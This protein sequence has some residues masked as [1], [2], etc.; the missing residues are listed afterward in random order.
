MITVET[1]GAVRQTPPIVGRGVLAADYNNRQ[2]HENTIAPVE[3]GTPVEILDK[4]DELWWRVRVIVA[5]RQADGGSGKGTNCSASF[6]GGSSNQP[7]KEGNVPAAFV[8]E[9]LSAPAPAPDAEPGPEL[10]EGVPPGGAKPSAPE[11]APCLSA[12]CAVDLQHS[13]SAPVRPASYVRPSH[14]APARAST[15]S[16]SPFP[17]VPM[18]DREYDFFINHCQKSGQDQCNALHMMLKQRGWRVWYDM[19]S[20]DL[21]EEGMEEGVSQS[22]NFLVF[23][24]DD[25]MSRS[26]CL[27]EQRWGLQYGC[28]FVG[29]VEKDPRHSPADFQK[30]KALAPEGL[31]FLFDNIEFEP[32]QRRAHYAAAM[33]EKLEQRAVGCDGH[34]PSVSE[35]SRPGCGATAGAQHEPTTS[36]PKLCNV[37]NGS[38]MTI[39]DAVERLRVDYQLT[40]GLSIPETILEARAKLGVA[41]AHRDRSLTEDLCEIC[42]ATGIETGWKSPLHGLA[43]TEFAATEFEM[44]PEPEAGD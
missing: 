16:M 31:K 37:M 13:K 21:T 23:L 7:C 22:R 15:G 8:T 3:K 12:G 2:G 6:D 40:E 27:K 17:A 30:E 28:H 10:P 25:L 44:E 34:T 26:F 19:A 39:K 36:Q 43:A 32:Y 14:P 5:N 9:E 1:A 20:D 33:I 41:P 4:H 11:L 42:A 24:S 29:V 38:K 35:G 18:E